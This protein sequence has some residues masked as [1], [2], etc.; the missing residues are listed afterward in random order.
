MMRILMLNYEF[1]PLGGGTGN[2]C[3]YLLKEFAKQPGLTIDVI[4]SSANNRYEEEQFAPNIRL[5]KLNVRKKEIHYW[6]GSEV[7]WWLWGAR[8]LAKKLVAQNHYGVIHSWAGWPSGMIG[9]LYSKKIPHVVALQGID[10][11]GSDA[12]LKNLDKLFFRRISRNIWRRA[13]AVTVLSQFSADKAALTLPC[14][15]RILRYGVATDEFTPA[16]T[17]LNS[18]TLRVLTV[19]RLNPIKGTQYTIHALKKLLN[20]KP[21][22]KIHFTHVGGGPLDAEM[23]NLVS[24]L[25]LENA[26]TFM[27][28]VDHKDLP[29]IYRENDVFV[30]PSL[31][32][33]MP[34]VVLEAIASGL[35]IITARHGG[36]ELVDGNGYVVEIGDSDAIAEKLG[37]LAADNDLL[38]RMRARSVE[39]APQHAW[40]VSAEKHLR[41]YEEVTGQVLLQP[42]GAAV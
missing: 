28:P 25:G 4:T 35:A 27:G 42:E 36:A 16:Q 39:L 30:L 14:D 11:P 33:G 21:G 29:Q 5:Y 19:A 10:I 26:V 6:R 32:E 41:L 1:P 7:L 34:N 37:L 22:I 24:K 9:D 3:Y 18:D 8:R 40:Q 23:K 38:A 17:P 12:R 13:K 31:S 2:V 15:F 20:E